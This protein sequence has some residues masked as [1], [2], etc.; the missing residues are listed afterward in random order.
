MLG[1][2]TRLDTFMNVGF[3]TVFV[4][5]LFNAVRQYQ[6]R[7]AHSKGSVTLRS[8]EREKDARETTPEPEPTAYVLFD[9]IG[10]AVIALGFMIAALT[11]LF[12]PL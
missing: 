10:H 9:A 2:N 1:Y 7:R 5:V 6:G 11:A 4:L 8:V 3:F 12:A